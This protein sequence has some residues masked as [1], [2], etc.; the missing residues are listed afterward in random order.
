MQLLSS[1]VTNIMAVRSYY[2]ISSRYF[3]DLIFT[4]QTLLFMKI[5]L[6]GV[7]GGRKII[8]R[9]RLGI[10][11]SYC[12][13]ILAELAALVSAT[14]CGSQSPPLSTRPNLPHAN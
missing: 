4:F 7:H 10:T 2:W 6:P 8:F 3:G 14:L 5:V 1:Y 11:A 12:G 9:L 13:S